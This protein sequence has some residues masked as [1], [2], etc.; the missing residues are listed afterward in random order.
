MYMQAST[1]HSPPPTSA[2][3]PAADD[4]RHSGTGC[5]RD[6]VGGSAGAGDWAASTAGSVAAGTA[7]V[8]GHGGSQDRARLVW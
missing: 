5:S 6:G 7:A 8:R 1:D 3:Q 4:G 2:G